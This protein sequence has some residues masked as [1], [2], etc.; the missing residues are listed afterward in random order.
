MKIGFYDTD[1]AGGM[2]PMIIKLVQENIPFRKINYNTLKSVK[3]LDLL[4]M[5]LSGLSYSHHYSPKKWLEDYYKDIKKVIKSNSNTKFLMMILGEEHLK[6]M[7]ERLGT[8]K[9]V[10]YVFGS[11]VS[12][13]TRFLEETKK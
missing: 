12:K 10:D 13:L 5:N 4:I 8:H 9:N 2:I 1:V 6:G 11:D 7:N 3:E